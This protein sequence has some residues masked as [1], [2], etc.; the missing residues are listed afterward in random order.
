MNRPAA[1]AALLSLSAI[2]VVRAA[3]CPVRL[4]VVTPDREADAPAQIYVCSSADGWQPAG[5]LLERVAPGIYAATL[6]FPPGRLE[7]KFTRTPSWTAVEKAADGSELPNRILEVASN[8]AEQVVLHVVLRWADRPPP[9]DVRLEISGAAGPAP[10]SRPRTIQGDV[11][12][13]NA[14]RSPQLD[15]ERPV[16]VWLPPGYDH[17]PT[18]RYPVLYLYDGQ[19]VF[20][21][22]TAFA[23][24][25]WQADETAARLIAERKIPPLIIVGVGNSPQR[26]DECTPARDARHGGGRADEYLA[27]LR[28]TL[29]PLIDRTY[30]TQ[31]EREHTAIAGSSLGGLLALYASFRCPETFGRVAALAPTLSWADG[32]VVDFVRAQRA[33]RPLRLWIDVDTGATED[34][35]P[36]AIVVQARRLKALFA[37]SGLPVGDEFHYEEIPGGR[38]HESDW[39]ARFD[40]VLT[41]LFGEAAATSRP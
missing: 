10:T 13:H 3:D 23:G 24:V 25:E 15:N 4:I 38:H 17:E 35:P 1:L 20:D 16:L 28:E 14:V 40:R 6:R 22:A 7:Y 32:A 41:F 37:E 30:R 12:I 33:T 26:M 34:A 36:D 11:R 21:A 2:S 18:R 29:K 8:L 19:N 27:F 31:P 5:R 9:A 39:A